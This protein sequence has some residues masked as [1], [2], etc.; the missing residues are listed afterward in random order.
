MKLSLSWIKE[1]LNLADNFSYS[2]LINVIEQLGY[3]IENVEEK[4]FETLCAAKVVKVVSV[5]KHPNADRLHLCKITDGITETV[6][7]CGAPNVYNGMLSVYLPAGQKLANGTIVEPKKIRGV[8]SNGMLCSAKELGLY[9]DHSGILELDNSF[10]VGTTLD[11]YLNDVIVEIS[12]PANRY[13]CLGHYGIA[14]EVAVKLNLELKYRFLSISELENKKLPFFDVKILSTELCKRYIAI[15]INNVNNKTQLPFYITYRI[16]SLGL[17]TINPLVDISNYVMLETGHSVH[18]FDYDKLSNGKIVVRNAKNGE[19]ITAL[20][21]KNYCLDE[22]V[23]V[24]ADEEKPVAIAGIIGGQNSCV[25][26]ETKNIVIESAMFNRSKIRLAKKQLGINTEASYRFERG[27]GWN[28]CE[29]AAM[30]IYQMITKYCGGVV[31]KFTD[32]KDMNYYNS[33]TSFYQNGIKVDLDFIS[34]FLG[35]KI[36]TRDFINLYRSLGGE[37]K[38][39]SLTDTT[40]RTFLVL[41]PLDRQDIKFQADVAEEIAR[42]TGYDSIPETL[43]HNILKS[44]LQ[45]DNEKFF[46][47]ILQYL[48]SIGFVQVINYSLCSSNENKTLL[49]LPNEIKTISVVNPVSAEYSELRVSLF[50]G[51]IKNVIL[52]YNNQ[53]DN[54][55]LAELGKVFYNRNENITEEYEIG[56][57]THGKFKLLSWQQNFVEYDLY[58]ISGVVETLLKMFDINFIKTVNEIQIDTLRPELKPDFVHYKISYF[59]TEHSWLISRVYELKKEKFKLPYTLCYAEIYI[60][61]IKQ[62]LKK[63]KIFVPLPKYPFVSRDLCLVIPEN[64][65]YQQV[66]K[67]VQDCF[68]EKN[69]DSQ[70][71]LSDYYKKEKV[72]TITIT[73]KI[74]DKNK[75]LTDEETNNIVSLIISKLN[76]YGVQLRQK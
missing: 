9:D 50:N 11:K 69:L 33:I 14:K 38:L 7:V 47:Q 37:I 51:L 15:Q 62:L 20:D 65:T 17:R 19:T 39:T 34:S 4:K 10:V 8:V 2:Q 60:E 30:K 64:I 24:I 28:L 23:I 71:I 53:I 43:P 74:W 59:D 46:N 40:T 52:N 76:S 73:L 49:F 27:S 41:P 22:N 26:N 16:N 5:E 1:I 48:T 25:D 56:L 29:L 57:I 42:F 72:T 70:I 12:T 18:I 61:K 58:Y 66:E 3:E 21:G 36:E 44:E 55:A 35:V 68:R 54:I 67:I 13:D 6:V 31:E 75:T 45:N 63:E 32:E